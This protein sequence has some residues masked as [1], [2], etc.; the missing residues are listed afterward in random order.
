MTAFLTANLIVLAALAAYLV[1]MS[2][3]QRYL[4]RQFGELRARTDHA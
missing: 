1:R 3:Y 4:V 2:L